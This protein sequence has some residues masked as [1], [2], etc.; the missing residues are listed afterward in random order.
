MVLVLLLL[1]WLTG[2]SDALLYWID[3]GTIGVL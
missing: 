2:H 1:E 3:L